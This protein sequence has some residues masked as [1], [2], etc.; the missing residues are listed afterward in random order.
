MTYPEL[1]AP[2]GNLERLQFA[3][4]Y[5]ADAVYV[6][7]D[8]YTMRTS[9]KNFTVE[10]LQ[11]GVEFAHSHGKKVY[12]TMNTVPTN[13]EVAKLPDYLRRIRDI[14]LD[15]LIVADL[16]VLAMA[17]KIVPD[18]DIHLST[19]V[20]I[21]NYMAANAAFDLGARRVVLARELSLQDI[22]VIRDNTPN[23]LELE[24]F[25]HGA[26]C[27]S[28]SGRCLLSHYLSGRDANRGEC[29][30][31]CRWK[32][33]LMEEHRPEHYF[34]IGEDEG[35]S[36]ILNANDLCTA[37]FIDLIC[38]AG[39]S[40]LKIEG[41]AKT[42]YYVASTTAAYRAALD[43]YIKVGDENP[44]VCPNE[45][46]IEL[47]KT[48]HRNYSTGFYFGKDGAKQETQSGKYI[49]DWEVIAVVDSHENGIAC[50]TQRGKFNVGDEIEALMP[51]GKVIAFTPERIINDVG[52]EI[53]ST[54]HAMMTF[55]IPCSEY[56]PQ[57][58]ILRKKICK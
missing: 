37:P 54:P 26:M 19:Q 51:S 30:Q 36:Y 32:W 38:K 16:G 28:F 8:M 7:G 45:V 48:S 24:A 55:T 27:M 58:T 22:A 5:G 23:E 34:E 20:G 39:V 21:A 9:P 43:E 31:P 29:T 25:V 57:Y 6:G 11:K 52:D 41:R 13:E 56:L 53:M 47:T 15:A 49:K 3:V 42:F 35:G 50:C 12:L 18:I 17:K 33:H 40:S 46:L 14:G 10:Q 1:L 44:F 4:L 2:A